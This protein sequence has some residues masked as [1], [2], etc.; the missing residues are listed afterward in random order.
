MWWTIGWITWLAMF[1]AIEGA[2]IFNKTPGD[3]LSE[4]VWRWF[5]IKDKPKGYRLRRFGFLA[6]W[7]WLTVHFFTG[8]WV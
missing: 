3:T 4:H 6:F 8:G 2:A 5:S 1:L 7:A